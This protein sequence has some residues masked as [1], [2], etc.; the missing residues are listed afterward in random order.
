MISSL[1]FICCI[2]PFVSSFNAEQ[3]KLSSHYVLVGEPI[4]ISCQIAKIQPLHSDYNLTWYRNGSDTPITTET[5]SRIHQ[6]DDLLWFIPATLEDSGLYECNIRNS[7]SSDKE[8]LQLNVFKNNDGLCFNGETMYKQKVFMSIGGK[9]TCP[10]LEYF[11]DENNTAPEIQ[12]YK[13]CKPGLL[14]DNRFLS[15][16]GD[17][18]LMI[19]NVTMHDKGNYTCKTTYTYMGIQH[20]VSRTIYVDVEE[21]PKKTPPKFIYPKNHSI[22]VELGSHVIMDCNISSSIG[23]LNPYWQV[24]G[25]DVNAFDDT[26]E[27]QFYEKPSL[28]GG[29]IIGARFNISKVKS[30]DYSHKFFCYVL[31]P[32]GEAVAYIVLKD[33]ASNIQGYLIGGLVSLVFVIVVAVFVCKLLK[34]DIVLWYRNSCH[35]FLSKEVSDGKIYDA[36]VLYPKN[37]VSCLYSPD[38]FALKI[39]PEVL[40]R[41]CGYNLF[42]FGRDDLPGQA[43][44]NVT[45]EKISQSRRVI[46]VLVPESSCYSVLEDISEQQLAVYNALIRDG[47]KIILIELDKIEDYTNMPESI[48][49]IKQKHGVIRWK[50]DFTEKSYSA[51]TKFWKNVRYQMPP[52]QTASPSE[53]QLLQT[54]FNSPHTRTLER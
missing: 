24:N 28:G 18:Y 22:E 15:S 38:I 29:F 47:I 49:Y 35:P 41:Q 34:I 8:Y 7:N 12:W 13:E 54:A 52:R 5:H 3:S 11:Y 14:Q 50:G 2:I 25:E 1:W 31:H 46:I 17:I 19:N 26:Y 6:Q 9:I 10:D 43:V 21:G 16:L 40:E 37:R 33:P 4:A 30:K 45:D 51:S 39:L 32:Y 36:Y 20:N 53:L 44:V 48:K 42:I 27:E 23:T